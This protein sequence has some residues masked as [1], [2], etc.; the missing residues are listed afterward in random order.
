MMKAGLIGAGIGFVLAIV[1]ALITPICNP[2]VAFLLGAG[3]GVLAAA[4]EHRPTAG[5]SANVG[6][7]AGAIATAGSL[8]GQMIGAVINGFLVGPEGLADL[9]FQLGLPVPDPNTYWLYNLG[10]N[11]V[12]ALLGVALGAGLGALGGL[13]W[14][15]IAG[16]NRVAGP[17][18]EE[19]GYP[20]G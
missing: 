7:Q 12:C 6:A 11:C 10:G 4:W 18:P 16:K 20:V 19:P 13:L 14:Y 3:I 8:L 5:G 9:Y 2:C 1:T 15:Q 17:P